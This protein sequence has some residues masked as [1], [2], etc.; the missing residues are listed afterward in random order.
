MV[1]II[2][3]Y[4]LI[5]FIFVFPLG[6][7]LSAQNSNSPHNF[8]KEKTVKYIQDKLKIADPV[9]S[10]F[11]LGDNGEL[12]IKWVNNGFFTE[13]RLNIREVD[14]DLKVSENGFNFIEITCM[15]DVNNCLQNTSRQVISLTGDKV[16]YTFHKTLKVESVAG[17][18]NI[19]SLNNA[20]KYLK[21]LSIQNNS[22]FKSEQRDPFLY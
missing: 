18:D 11:I 1:S 14:F 5:L 22:D 16:F 19:S 6:N 20:L 10:D 4:I 13:Y 3:I 21:I 2:N 12:L 7:N 9:Y 15:S 17:F 8:T